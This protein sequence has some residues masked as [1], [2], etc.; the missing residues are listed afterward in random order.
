MVSRSKLSKLK[1]FL[2]IDL[3]IVAV[4]AGLYLYL[5]NEGT[6]TGASKPATFTFSDLTINPSEAYIGET[7]LIS[8]N[9][10]NI[11]DVE[12]N[13]TVNLEINDVI[14]DSRNITL[15][16]LKSSEIIEFTDIEMDPGNYSVKIEDLMGSFLIEM[17]PPDTSK[18]VLSN[19]RATPYEAW[20]NETVTVTANA[21]NPSSDSDILFI[22]V[23]VDDVLVNSTLI[24]LEAGESRTLEFSV[25]ATTEGKHTVKLNSL[26]GSFTIVKTGYHTVMI[27]RSGGGSHSLPFTLN[28]E[29][30]GTPYTALLPVGDY[31]ISVPTPYD[32]GTGVLGF[33]SWSDGVK[34]S[35]RS[36]T[37]SDRLILVASYYLISGYASCPSLYI[38]NGTGYSYVTEVSNSGWLG[39]IGYMNSIGDITFVGGNPWDYVKLDNE[40]LATRNGYFDL[41]LSQQWDELFYLDSV[42]FLAVD[43]PIGTDAYMTMT[44]YLNDG[45]TGQV[46]TV[47][48][49]LLPPISAVNEKG[50]DVLAMILNKDGVFTPG[51]NVIQSPTWNNLSYNQLTLDL[52]D[53]SDAEYLKLVITGIVDWGPPEPYYEYIAKFKEA[54]KQGLI[55]DKAEITPPPIMEIKAANGSWVLVPQDK[56]IPIPSD[57]NARTF[58]VDLTGLFPDDVEEYQLRITNYWNVTYDYIAIDTTA[59]V[60]LNVQAIK[61]TSAVL[62]QVW[63]TLSISSG[64]FTRYGDVK[65]LVLEAD[66]MYVVGRQGDRVLLK[67]DADELGDVSEGMERDYFLAVA[68]WFKDPPGNWGYGFDFTVDPL[69]FIDMS[70][71]PYTD[72]E[73]YPYDAEHLEYLQTYNTRY[74]NP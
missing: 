22:R 12:G 23:M 37:V 47:G 3:L 38:W 66:D 14:K 64:Y 25:N 57:Y 72:A 61:P 29:E 2:I 51:V 44:Y 70:G 53:L 49:N 27:N 28:G 65:P 58:A 33:D 73:S 48:K 43:H 6:I 36:F 50:D 55:F 42:E 62:D 26:S 11:G 8:A 54:A 34:S 69:P 71:F 56:Q 67:F 59:P 9:V 15:A 19:F 18:I 7:I 46:Y 16:G 63:E 17:P 21:N 20:A 24:E 35:S 41:A 32:V 10:T 40:L 45:S 5:L 68:C 1:A 13:V 30:H 74:I 4:A 39:Y 60:E 52:G 31:T